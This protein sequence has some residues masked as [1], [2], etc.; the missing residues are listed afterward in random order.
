MTT[1]A[2]EG[3]LEELG[4]YLNVRLAPDENQSCLIH[5]KDDLDVQI[6]LTPNKEYLIIGSDLGEVGPGKFS[7]ELF[8]LALKANNLPPP[9][10]GCLAYNSNKQH[11]IL[12]EMM[13]FK[14]LSADKVV[15]FL[16]PFCQKAKIWKEAVTAKKLPILPE[17][18]GKATPS[19]IFGLK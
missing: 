7:E 17:L 5:F 15:L 8:L 19:G 3:L 12:F 4:R 16:E 13:L 14:E 18:A 1:D 11:L 6:E 2:F 10:F 9:L